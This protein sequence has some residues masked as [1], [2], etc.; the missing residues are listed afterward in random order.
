MARCEVF[1]Y[2]V[3]AAVRDPLHHSPQHNMVSRRGLVENPV[4]IAIAGKST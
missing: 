4:Q 1:K 3:R 2:E